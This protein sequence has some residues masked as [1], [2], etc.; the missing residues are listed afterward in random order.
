MWYFSL[1][2]LIP[3]FFVGL[4]I[5]YLRDVKNTSNCDEINSPYL[6][7]YYYYY[8][9]DM[10]FLIVLMLI[11][12]SLLLSISSEFKK[13]S[14]FVKNNMKKVK[15]YDR[16]FGHTFIHTFIELLLL[17]FFIKLLF[18]I[19]KEDVCKDV[20][21]GLRTFLLITNS[22]AFISILSN[23]IFI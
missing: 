16:K 1:I 20:D 19:S 21:P 4:T 3:I 12:C 13:F 9:L 15:S 14:K 5:K 7:F 2:F 22:I 23:I 17:G 11:T 10:I 8:W 6:T 18:D